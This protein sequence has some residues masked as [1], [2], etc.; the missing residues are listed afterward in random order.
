MF[1]TL[2]DVLH[3]LKHFTIPIQQ[4]KKVSML[5]LEASLTQSI[6]DSLIVTLLATTNTA[7]VLRSA[8]GCW[9]T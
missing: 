3:I 6:S 9:L 2:D 8:L 7:K 5:Y 4:N 1:N